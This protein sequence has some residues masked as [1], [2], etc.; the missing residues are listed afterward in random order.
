[1]QGRSKP[2]MLPEWFERGR[3]RWAWGGW[4]LC[5]AHGIELITPDEGTSLRTADGGG[6]EVADLDTYAVLRFRR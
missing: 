4:E 1:M 6:W 3:I 5:H 2:G